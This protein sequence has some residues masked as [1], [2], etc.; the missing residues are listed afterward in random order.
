L[1][2]A[3]LKIYPFGQANVPLEVHV[4]QIGNLWCTASQAGTN[5]STP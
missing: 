1:S 4:P 2:I 5:N 3:N